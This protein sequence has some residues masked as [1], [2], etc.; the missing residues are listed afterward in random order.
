MQA[1]GSVNMHSQ[2]ITFAKLASSAAKNAGPLMSNTEMEKLDN[3]T[4]LLAVLP[5][6]AETAG[7][8][9]KHEGNGFSRF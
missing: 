9:P 8:L 3:E 7:M 1:L 6:S 5:V 4:G 2:A